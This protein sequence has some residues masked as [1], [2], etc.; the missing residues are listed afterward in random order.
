MK[1]AR[2]KIPWT[3]L[4]LSMAIVTVAISVQVSQK[5]AASNEST[6][7]GRRDQAAMK[8]E[9]KALRSRAKALKSGSQAERDALLADWKKFAGKYNAKTHT[10]TVVKGRPTRIGPALESAEGKFVTVSKDGECPWLI[11]SDTTQ[12]VK[13]SETQY[14][15][16]YF[17]VDIPKTSQEKQP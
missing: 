11:E 7:P 4:V 15:C 10:T 9:L 16:E 5:T 13:T 2:T 3:S 12:C 1:Q 14:Q 6:V 17:C 8:Q